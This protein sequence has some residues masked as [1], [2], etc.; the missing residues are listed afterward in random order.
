MKLSM[1]TEKYLCDFRRILTEM[2]KNMTEIKF[3]DSISGDF[4]T[5]MIPH[6]R[7]AIEMSENLL[8]YTINCPLESI[9]SDIIS[10]QEKSIKNMLVV[11]SKCCK[12]LNSQ[13]EL[14]SYRQ[15]NENILETMFRN[16]KSACSN[17][18]IDAD[19][20]REMIPHHIGA[21]RMSENALNFNI[22]N[23][24]KPIMEAII[25]SQKQGVRKMKFLLSEIPC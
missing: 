21:I 25:I 9:A 23:E 14:M 11:R 20:M 7:A 24:L 17:N 6:H 12:I 22:C 4:I 3:T 13:N 2:I 15:N 8:K 19:F 10:S 1:N 18:N 16:M 5:Q